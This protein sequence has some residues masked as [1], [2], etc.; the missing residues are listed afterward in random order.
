MYWS[1]ILSWEVYPVSKM[2]EN[3]SISVKHLKYSQMPL[4]R[5]A[6][7]R[8]VSNIRQG[9]HRVWKTWKNIFFW[10]S[11]GKSWNFEKS[12]KVM[13]KSWNFENPVPKNHPRALESIRNFTLI[14]FPDLQCH[15]FVVTHMILN[16]KKTL[17]PF[18]WFIP[19][20]VCFQHFVNISQYD[21]M[22]MV[23]YSK[24]KIGKN[25]VYILPNHS[26][27]CKVFVLKH[28]TQVFLL[29][30]ASQDPLFR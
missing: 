16:Y 21:F 25:Q 4:K 14:S 19:I 13:E 17:R 29:C 26:L 12:S 1:H 30:T 9:S 23:H 10:K 7:Y 24:W 18:L 27:P 6:I 11:H 28:W 5:S 22:H 15:I 8:K 20:E 3:L 2:S